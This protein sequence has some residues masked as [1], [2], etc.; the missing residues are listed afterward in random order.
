MKNCVNFMQQLQEW[1][2]VV[3]GVSYPLALRALQSHWP[4]PLG[5]EEEPCRS[6]V[7]QCLT[8]PPFK[9]LRRVEAGYEAH[10]DTNPGPTTDRTQT[11]TMTGTRMW[12]RTQ[13]NTET[14]TQTWPRRTKDCQ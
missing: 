7:G 1:E 4:C 10:T 5:V 11:E 2:E 8:P 14:L 12:T 3:L 6:S 13:T 9:S